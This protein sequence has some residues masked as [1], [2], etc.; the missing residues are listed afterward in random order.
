MDSDRRLKA[1]GRHR[2]YVRNVVAGAAEGV[3]HRVT[4]PLPEGLELELLVRRA[5]VEVGRFHRQVPLEG[6]P[7]EDAGTDGHDGEEAAAD[8]DD[9]Q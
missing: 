6:Q 8:W 9:D 5:E 3:D 4:Q 7:D 2:R 1:S